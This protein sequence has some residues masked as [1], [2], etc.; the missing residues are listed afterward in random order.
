M[1]R[2]ALTQITAAALLADPRDLAN[3]SLLGK[4]LGALVARGLAPSDDATVA[5]LLPAGAA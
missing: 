5:L 1:A 4:R 3:P 2:G